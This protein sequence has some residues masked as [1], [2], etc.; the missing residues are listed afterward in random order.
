MYVCMY[1]YVGG[2]GPAKVMDETFE[3]NKLQKYVQGLKMHSVL[4]NCC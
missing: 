4:G 1:T 3:E 2:P